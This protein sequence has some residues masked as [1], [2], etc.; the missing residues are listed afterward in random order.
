VKWLIGS[1]LFLSALLVGIASAA[2]IWWYVVDIAI[3]QS[4]NADRSM[5]FWGLPILFL[6]I[7]LAAGAV[8]LAALAWRTMPRGPGSQGAQEPE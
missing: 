5:L 1:L 8:G 6:G 3:G 2:S 4:G 7:V